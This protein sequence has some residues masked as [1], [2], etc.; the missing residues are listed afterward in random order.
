MIPEEINFKQR[1]KKYISRKGAKN[2]KRLRETRISEAGNVGTKSK[3]FSSTNVVRGL[4]FAPLREP[5]KS[6][7][8]IINLSF[9]G[10]RGL[11]VG[12]EYTKLNS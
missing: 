12:Q 1:I 4:G 2:A 6:G 8:G 11:R 3:S 9:G 10:L 7:Q 5:Q